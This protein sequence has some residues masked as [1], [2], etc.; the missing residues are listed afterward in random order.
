[1]NNRTLDRLK[2]FDGLRPSFSAHVSW[3]EHG[4]PVNCAAARTVHVGW[5]ELQVPPIHFAPSDL[6]EE[7]P[8]EL[9]EPRS[10]QL[11]T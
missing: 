4:A 10:V 11:T 3:C 8:R 1:M 5:T 7:L 9:N 6:E 2:A